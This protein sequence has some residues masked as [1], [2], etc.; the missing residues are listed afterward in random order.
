ME[1]FE[2][3]KEDSVLGSTEP[4]SGAPKSL[5]AGLTPSLEKKSPQIIT[6]GSEAMGSR[7]STQFRFIRDQH[8]RVP[9]VKK[10]SKPKITLQ[11]I[12]DDVLNKDKWQS[13]WKKIKDFVKNKKK[14]SDKQMGSERDDV[15]NT[16]LALYAG[17]EEEEV[18][19]ELNSLYERF[20]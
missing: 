7:D 5:F 8:Q 12:L 15:F 18:F 6:Q 16:L 2:K 11:R 3:L 20:P 10:Q 9:L 4:S 14:E 17:D 19:A 1:N 13:K